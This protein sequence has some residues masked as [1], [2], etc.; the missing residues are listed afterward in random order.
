[1]EHLILRTDAAHAFSVL[2]PFEAKGFEL[3][4]LKTRGGGALIALRAPASAVSAG[5]ALAAKMRDSLPAGATLLAS[6]LPS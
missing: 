5:R 1:M 3:I 2:A 4:G 6:C